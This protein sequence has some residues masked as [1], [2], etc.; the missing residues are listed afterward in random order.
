MSF[1]LPCYLLKG[2]SRTNKFPLIAGYIGPCSITRYYYINLIFS[3]E[4][5]IIYLGR[6]FFTRVPRILKKKY[7]ACGMI[8][9]EPESF[10]SK[11]MQNGSGFIIPK[12][13]KMELD[14]S[15]SL[16]EMENVK[17]SGYRNIVR[18][19]NKHEFTYARSENPDDFIRFYENMYLPY[20]RYRFAGASSVWK[21]FE[22]FPPA[23]HRELLLIKKKNDDIG[24]LVIDYKADTATLCFFGVSE[25]CV[26]YI[27][28]G[29][30]GA[31]YYFAIRTLQSQGYKKIHLGDSRSFI[32]DGVI[33]FKIRLLATIERSD[34]FDIKHNIYLSVFQYSPGIKDFLL[35]N[36]FIA[37]SS[38][39]EQVGVI[40]LSNEKELCE[41]P[42]KKVFRRM[43]RSGIQHL[44]I[45]VFGHLK[46]PLNLPEENQSMSVSVHKANDY[47]LN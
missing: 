5:E 13:V 26:E 29:L 2:T 36:P 39:G 19:I 47:I 16:K 4:P 35:N 10:L 25:Y 20:A 21:F 46:L 37:I 43:E 14:I 24:G 15:N 31:L 8:L 17:R 40:W 33:R 1:Y 45:N 34:K 32:N 12:W 41:E 6:F 44:K 28:H 18:L 7:P 11:Q 30:L 3:Y 23:A 38:S 22:V 27:N 42:F 9:Y